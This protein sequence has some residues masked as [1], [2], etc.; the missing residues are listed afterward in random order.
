M[1]KCKYF[2]ILII[3]LIS[4]NSFSQ[5]NYRSTINRAEFYII[6]QKYDSASYYYK[7]SFDISK[8]VLGKDYYNAAVCAS[9]QNQFTEVNEY[10]L[11]LIKRGFD[12]TEILKKK[13]FDGFKKSIYCKN[14]FNI[15]K[16]DSSLINP[17]TFLLKNQLDSMFADD[18]YFRIRNPRDYMNHEYRDIIKLIDSI[19]AI[20]LI[21]IMNKY[22][23][24]NEFYTGYYNNSLSV[25]LPTNI[26]VIHQQNG[27]PSRVVDFSKYLL[28]AI[29]DEKTLPNMLVSLYRLTI[30]QDIIIDSIF[31]INNIFKITRPNGSFIYAFK[32]YSKEKEESINKKRKEF[33]LDNIESFRMLEL[34]NLTNNM[35]FVFDLGNN[36]VEEIPEEIATQIF[37]KD[38]LNYVK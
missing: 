6:N 15:I 11:L 2:L 1:I 17:N 13:S 9:L 8:N 32:K 24:P 36:Y 37:K 16:S 21:S 23:F 7:K 31:G 26:I 33:N 35:D 30:G 29:K 10:L 22:G 27:S 28:D 5:N 19:N 20:K 12:I 4:L 14:L 25:N 34:Y 18:R 3:I 38:Y